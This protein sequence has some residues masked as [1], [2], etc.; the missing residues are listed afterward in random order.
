M[1]EDTSPIKFREARY[2][3]CA[4]RS[5]IFKIERPGTDGQ[6]P[7]AA[8]LIDLS[9]GGV[10]LESPLCLASGE[11]VG[12]RLEVPEIGL[13]LQTAAMV[14]WTRP[15]P[16]GAW[17]AGCAVAPR[18]PDAVLS[19]LSRQGFLERR[20]EERKSLDVTFPARWEMDA[21]VTRVR[22]VDYSSG[23]FR[24]VST[25]KVQVGHRIRMDID[26]GETGSI[27]ARVVWQ[28]KRQDG[29]LVGCELP[30]W[31]SAKRFE[32]YAQK[33]AAGTPDGEDRKETARM[34]GPPTNVEDRAAPDSPPA[35]R[36]KLAR[37]ILPVALVLISYLA[38]RL[39]VV[40]SLSSAPSAARDRKRDGQP[41]RTTQPWGSRAG[42]VAARQSG[43]AGAGPDRLAH[44]ES[45]GKASAGRPDGATGILTAPAAADQPST[46]NVLTGVPDGDRGRSEV[47]AAPRSGPVNP[48]G[49]RQDVHNRSLEAG[50]WR[51]IEEYRDRLERWPMVARTSLGQVQEELG[52]WIGEGLAQAARE[53]RALGQANRLAEPAV[54]PT[55]ER[56]AAAEVSHGAEPGFEASGIAEGSGPRLELVNPVNNGQAVHFLAGDTVHSLEPGQKHDLAGG[57][58]T[59]RIRFHR[60]GDFGN[61]EYS[62]S[63]GVFEF[64]VAEQGWHLERVSETP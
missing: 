28:L 34:D 22:I 15:T 2:K 36:R 50:T 23:G 38:A 27:V 32:S 61:A 29:Y 16:E 17:Q 58:G 60:G 30:D 21:E 35:R 4:G 5:V 62:L 64:R 25:K 46:P 10:R 59:W 12:V 52:K 41:S 18:I 8:E 26:D 42:P 49:R 63:H 14:Q 24:L 39:L 51:R 54:D 53:Y 1:P 48:D 6:P 37:Y 3:R 57:D 13:E 11:T 44:G 43:P 7:I 31:G 47:P 40:H 20:R 55:R 33:R 19:E 56:T 9:G 45:Q